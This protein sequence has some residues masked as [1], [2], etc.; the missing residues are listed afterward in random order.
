MLLRSWH[1]NF[2]RMVKTAKSFARKQTQPSKKPIMNEKEI[3]LK[4][5]LF[6]IMYY[7]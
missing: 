6:I 5:V 2:S 4:T 7:S 1:H 3:R